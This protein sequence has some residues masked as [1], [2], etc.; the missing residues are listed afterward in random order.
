MGSKT[1]ITRIAY[2]TRKLNQHSRARYDELM[3]RPTR[4]LPANRM[5][6][7]MTY[8]AALDVRIETERRNAY[9]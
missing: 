1:L 8:K 4:T 6:R 7:L 2:Y 3:R 5:A 9:V